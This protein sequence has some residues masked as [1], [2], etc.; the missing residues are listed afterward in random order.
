MFALSTLIAARSL[1]WIQS[2][3]A[4]RQE[5]ASTMAL[6]Q[7]S[8]VWEPVEQI[9]GNG[10]LTIASSS[11]LRHAFS[12]LKYAT[13]YSSELA[14]EFN[15][16]GWWAVYSSA[17]SGLRTE[18]IREYF[19]IHPENIHVADFAKPYEVQCVHPGISESS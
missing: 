17:F 19:E 18:N 15:A 3:I 9:T 7:G 6:I 14:R 12:D 2:M 16:H 10:K 5:C 13:K 8:F 4:H 1:H 11:W